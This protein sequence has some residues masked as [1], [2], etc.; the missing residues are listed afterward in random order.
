[1][2]SGVESIVSKALMTVEKEIYGIHQSDIQQ[3]QNLD[4][5]EALLERDLELMIERMST[6]Q[7]NSNLVETKPA[8]T[9]PT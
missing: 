1:M 5:E 3:I 8:V 4:C 7:W 2:D 6:S 9:A